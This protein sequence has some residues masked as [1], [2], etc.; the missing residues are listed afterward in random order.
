VARIL[1]GF[2]F[3][4]TGLNGFLNFLPQP[5]KPLPEGAMAFAGAMVNTGYLLPLAMGTQL[6]VGLLLLCNRWVPLAL[7]V[8][9]PVI[10]N[11]VAFHV[12][13]APSGLPPALIVL[14]LELYLAWTC[15]G[16]YRPM[17]VWRMTPRS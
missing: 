4:V 7:A 16:R 11:I 3:T 12:F 1:M 17:L 14:V 5:A 13:L 9:A 6:A 15:R 2:I 8:I 10:V